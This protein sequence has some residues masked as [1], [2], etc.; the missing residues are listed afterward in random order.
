MT[1]LFSPL[2]RL[3]PNPSWRLLAFVLPMN[4]PHLTLPLAFGFL[5]ACLA[6]PAA[7]SS[8]DSVMPVRGLCV[9]APRAAQ[10][11]S[12]VKFIEDDL[13]PRS[14]NT[15][16]L[17]V[18][19]NYQYETHPELRD[20]SAL[21]KA[22]VKKLVEA[23]RKHGIRLIPQVNLLGHQS[24]HGRVGNL[25]RAYPEFD[26]TPQVKLP[27]QY[28]WP[29]P[30][31]LYCKSYCPLH[32]KVHE[33]VFAVMD[34]ICDAF[35]TDAFHAGMDEVFY[36]GED[37]CSRCSGRD[38]A[39][40]FANEAR[41]IRDHLNARG[42]ELWMWGDR[43]LDGKVTGV[44]EWEGSMNNTHRAV[45]LIPKDVVIC[46]WHY[47]RPDPTA[48]YLAL[49]G[50]SVVTCPWKNPESAVQ[51]TKDM[52]QLRKNSAPSIRRRFAGMVQTVWSDAG[53]FLSE[54]ERYKK[55]GA[56]EV[57]ANSQA[58]CFVTLFD[59]IGRLKQP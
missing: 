55:G 26:E 27:E 33:V 47:D 41:R 24:W 51:Q 30:D 52:V 20:G 28:Q 32:P 18:E 45:D 34:E 6:L 42:R 21:S 50:F 11:E 15:L 2:S 57:G 5:L 19:Y 4:K 46:D 37:Q 8:L 48:A 16:I 25:L 54:M 12:F 38:K 7:E 31:R 56:S 23:C 35:E 22:E 40:L 36:I 9:G 14:V 13:A 10:V 3:L 53:G 17:R 44:G 1:R 39:E 58:N 49:K 43:L 29:N 59:E